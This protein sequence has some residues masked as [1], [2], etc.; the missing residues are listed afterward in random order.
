MLVVLGG[1]EE[2]H[3]GFMV[4]WGGFPK[5]EHETWIFESMIS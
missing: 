1:W 4:S 2:Q 3:W 5:T